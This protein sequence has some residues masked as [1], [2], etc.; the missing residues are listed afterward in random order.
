MSVDELL[1]GG[2]CVAREGKARPGRLDESKLDPAGQERHAGGERVRDP[3]EAQQ[4]KA[5]GGPPASPA[6]RRSCRQPVTGVPA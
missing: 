2:L 6:C 4:G 5:A 3:V 1:F